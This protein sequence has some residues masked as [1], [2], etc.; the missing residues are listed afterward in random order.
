MGAG[1][2]PAA[3]VGPAVVQRAY[4]TT[5]LPTRVG[6]VLEVIAEDTMSGW[7]WCRSSSDRQRWVPSRT[8][9]DG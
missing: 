6:E 1:T 7:L 9:E 3:A 2:A 4:D 5:K 8:V